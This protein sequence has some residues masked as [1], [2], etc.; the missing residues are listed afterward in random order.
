MGFND[1]VVDRYYEARQKRKK[2]LAAAR[3]LGTHTKN[4]WESLKKSL[5]FR[6][7]KCGEKG[8]HLDKDHIVPLYLGGSDGIDNIQPL[9]AP[10]NA[11]K[12]PDTTN[13]KAMRMEY[14]FDANA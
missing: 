6:C 1:P 5:D 12:G 2:R 14:G 7:A 10:C 11:R 4:E 8:W 13:W 3:L 9:C